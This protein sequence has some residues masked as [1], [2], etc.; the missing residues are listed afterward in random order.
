MQ[1]TRWIRWSLPAVIIPA[2]MAHHNGVAEEQDRDRTGAPGSDAPCSNT[3][4]HDDG[5][6]DPEFTIEVIDMNTD[7]AIADYIPGT[8]YQLKFTVSAPGAL[9]YGFQA[10]ALIDSDDSNAGQFQ[11]PGSK[12]Q[13]EN[14]DGRHI[15]EHSNTSF[16]GVFLAEWVAPETGS[17][18]VT[19]YGSSLAANAN[20][21]SSG[22][23]YSGS[24]L[25]LG[26]DIGDAVLNA[27]ANATRLYF[28]GTQ[29]WV[30][31][32]EPGEIWVYNIHG[33]LL[34]HTSYASGKH[35]IDLPGNT[36]VMVHV[37]TASA[38]RQIWKGIALQ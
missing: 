9:G 13:L 25:T 18:P 17:G 33:Q 12:T 36:L 6:F 14:V 24:T 29:A 31:L 19:F 8:T 22:D 21:E 4:C 23:G 7:L 38:S 11:N 30:Y 37:G 16:T 3:L 32:S 28:E 15:V 27:R 26:E 10:T 35:A 20:Q 1:W 2:L 34:Q 5:E